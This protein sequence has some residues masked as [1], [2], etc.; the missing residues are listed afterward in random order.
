MGFCVAREDEIKAFK[1]RLYYRVRVSILTEDKR[2]IV[3][4]YDKG[5]IFNQ[6]E[7]NKVIFIIL[8]VPGLKLRKT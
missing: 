2:E 6:A 1:P 7:A 5:H 8:K 3:S 4:Y